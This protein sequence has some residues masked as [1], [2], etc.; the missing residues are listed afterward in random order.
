MDAFRFPHSIMHDTA[1]QANNEAL[2]QFLAARWKKLSLL[3]GFEY[4]GAPWPL[5]EYTRIGGIVRLRGLV[6]KPGAAWTVSLPIG[7]LPKG[8]RPKFT[9]I[10]VTIGEDSVRST[11]GWRV[12]VT[13]TGL[14]ELLFSTTSN[15]ASGGLVSYLPL[16]GINFIAEQ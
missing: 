9:E 12:D 7:E 8:Y 13:P 14:V 16:T 5:P 2:E 11:V 15:V 1:Q 6:K 3:N 4:Y 10:F